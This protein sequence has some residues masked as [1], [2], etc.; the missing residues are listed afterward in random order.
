MAIA[1]L[2]ILAAGKSKRMK[3]TKSKVLHPLMG[4]P[5]IAYPL[6]LAQK[7]KTE[8]TIVI[9]N[10][11]G[12]DIK[13]ALKDSGVEFAIQ[14]VPKGTGDAV[15]A[16]LPRLKD[17]TGDVLILYGDDPLLSFE[18]LDNL[19]KTHKAA[20]AK[21]TILTALFPKPPAFGRI[22][23]AVDGRA[24]EIVED[25]DCDHEQKKIREV[26]AGVYC[27]DV[28]FLKSALSELKSD[29]KQGEF[30]LTDIV[31]LAVNKNIRVESSQALDWQE[32]FGINTRSE[33]ATAM[34]IMRKKINQRW[35]SEGVTIEDPVQVIIEPDV[36]IG[37]DT[38]IESGAR[39]CGK[40]SIGKN[41][42]IEAFSRISDS[43]IENNVTV[44]QGTMIE[45]TTI[46]SGT[47]IGPMARTRPGSL[48]GKDVRI[49][50]FVE[51]KKTVIGDRTKA[52]H[53]TYLGDAVVGKDCNI[54]CG[55]ITCNYDGEKK[56]Q[57]V[58][59][60]NVFV[61][62]DSQLV[63]PVRVKK[64]AYIASGSTITDE[65]PAGALALGRS[66]QVNKPGWNKK[67]TKGGKK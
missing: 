5:L 8:K 3:T 36:T 42:V 60:D 11:E 49:G 46:K 51:L 61:G 7:L 48:L 24:L 67:K 37:Q 26:N 16:G 31:K 45:E 18:T 22:I 29:N 40:T 52:S 65:V 66:R 41:C 55:T 15:K 39:L 9:I 32:T 59:E 47:I 21:L 63:A 56:H 64:G 33:L 57:T 30:Y 38:V 2:M 13:T 27:V 14:K 58:I 4:K 62:S 35:M 34:R 10:P 50:N 43:T 6:E 20:K 44:R 1:A 12:Q 23:R 54:A 53:L 25:A 17:L 19:V 28:A